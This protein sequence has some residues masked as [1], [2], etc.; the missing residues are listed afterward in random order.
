MSTYT[1]YTEAYKYS[2]ETNSIEEAVL[3]YAKDVMGRNVNLTQ[4]KE[5]LLDMGI[6]N[7]EDYW[8][9]KH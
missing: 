1:L 8:S 3:S 9:V 4:W 5:Y 2:V 7:S 6:D